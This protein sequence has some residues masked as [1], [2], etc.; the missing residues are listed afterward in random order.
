MNSI[1]EIGPGMRL[2][3]FFQLSGLL[4]IDK[5]SIKI[6]IIKR[7]ASKRCSRRPFHS[8]VSI[9]SQFQFQFPLPSPFPFP[10]P[11]PFPCLRIPNATP[12]AAASVR[13]GKNLEKLS[14]LG[15]EWSL[16]TIA[17]RSPLSPLSLL[18]PLCPFCLLYFACVSQ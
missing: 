2:F 10:F 18:C 13:R 7:R 9:Q 1:F 16:V 17:S 6:I 3:R 4:I 5:S 15:F 14:S 8:A 12:A 11:F